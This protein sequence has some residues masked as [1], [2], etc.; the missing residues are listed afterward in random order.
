VFELAFGVK[1]GILRTVGLQ[2][3][4]EFLY[5]CA[6]GLDLVLENTESV[7]FRGQKCSRLLG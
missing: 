5:L 6:M 1:V 3:A 4:E 2:L 7:K